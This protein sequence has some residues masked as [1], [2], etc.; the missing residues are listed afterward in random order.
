MWI[1]EIIEG[2]LKGLGGGK[3]LAESYRETQD[4][5]RKIRS[6]TPY[7]CAIRTGRRVPHPRHWQ[8]LTQIVG[9]SASA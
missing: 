5:M 7:A 4:R 9:V 2:T 1:A 3:G 8:A 6:S